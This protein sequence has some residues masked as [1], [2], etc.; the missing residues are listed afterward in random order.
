MSWKLE[1]M[2]LA[3]TFTCILI[4]CFDPYSNLITSC[5]A[6]SFF[7]LSSSTS[8]KIDTKLNAEEFS[9]SYK[10]HFRAKVAHS[11]AKGERRENE[12]QAAAR[13][14][15]RGC[16]RPP[17]LCVCSVLPSEKLKTPN[18]EIIILQHPNERR[19]KNLSTVPLLKLILSDIK[20]IAGYTFD[21]DHILSNNESRDKKPFLLYPSDG[22]ISLDSAIQDRS[23]SIN[24]MFQTSNNNILSP[25]TEISHDKNVLII[26]D[27]TWSEAKRM[28]RDSPNLLEK[29]QSVQFSS[30]NQTSIYD[31]IRKEPEEH[32]LS[33]LEAC[34]LCLDLIETKYDNNK[35]DSISY[36][37]FFGKVLQEHVDLHLANSKIMSPRSAGKAQAKLYA[38]NRRR[39]EI[40]LEMFS[41]TTEK[42]TETTSIS[43][44]SILPDGAIIRPLIPEDAPLVNSWWEYGSAKSLSLVR[45]RIEIDPIG[46]CFGISSKTDGLNDG[47]ELVACIMRYEGGAIGMLHVQESHRR[48]GYALALLKYVTQILQ[49]QGEERVACK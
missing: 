45:R 25:K 8:K 35:G 24:E 11:V 30:P 20:V 19:K 41:S 48:R 27:G 31:A 46:I 21:I 15:C 37:Q 4:I 26:I 40:E 28:V 10:P 33:T 16:F 44:S 42:N 47:E 9:T 39:R 38:K 32:C 2:F 23:T 3:Y 1:H 18:T 29:C 36:T 6:F 5:S 7:P 49:D 13:E 12:R 43:I 22:A 34:A 14:I 17:S